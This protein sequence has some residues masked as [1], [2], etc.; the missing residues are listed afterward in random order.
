MGQTYILSLDLH[1]FF[2]KL[3]LI[4][5]LAHL[6]LVWLKNK[7]FAYIKRLMFFLPAY[8]CV[9]ACIVFSGFL[10]L[11][12]L[13]FSMNASIVAML[14]ASVVLIILGAK[15]FKKLKA[16]R[17]NNNIKNFRIFMSIKILLEMLVI[18]ITTIISVKF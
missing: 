6:V 7:N 11:A 5:M 12:L 1:L 18:I 15:G 13:H 9:L 16:L 14:V 2:V 3:I 4:F 17:I 10:N 8:Y